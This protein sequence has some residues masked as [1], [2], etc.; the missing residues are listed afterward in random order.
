MRTVN[1]SPI[2]RPAIKSLQGIAESA[3]D[4]NIGDISRGLRMDGAQARLALTALSPAELLMEPL[5]NPTG[6]YAS[7]VVPAAFVLIIQQTLLMGAATL[8]ALGFER[9]PGVGRTRL[10]PAGVFGRSLARLTIYAAAL[11]L[12]FIVL[13]RVYGFSTLGRVADLALFAV[14]FVLATSFMG[15][16]A[17]SLF[18]HRETAVLV[19][20]ATTLPQFFLVGVSWPREMIPP[21]LQQLRRIFPSE[22]AIDGLVRIGQMGA[23]L[24]EVRAD[25]LYLWLLT[26]VYF[27]LAVIVTRRRT[28]RDA[29][30]SV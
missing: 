6:G 7:Y 11:A 21:A 4:T 26:A 15:Q 3:A 2:F 8:T 27:G 13:P 20:V 25:W 18:R 28:A 16:A 1:R 22:S 24:A 10:G 29:I 12:F 9:R 23:S 30:H 19:F 17:G 14:P 5:Y